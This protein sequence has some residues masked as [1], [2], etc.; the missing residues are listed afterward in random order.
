MDILRLLNL[1]NMAILHQR[2]RNPLNLTFCYRDDEV[3]DRW[4]VVLGQVP[5]ADGIGW[6]GGV[7]AGD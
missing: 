6:W 5:D 4:Q 3:F 2:F 1:V 7:R